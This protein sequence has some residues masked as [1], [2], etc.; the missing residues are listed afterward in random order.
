MRVRPRHTLGPSASSSAS[1]THQTRLVS[2]EYTTMRIFPIMAPTVLS[3]PKVLLLVSS[4]L[5]LVVLRRVQRVRQAWQAP[6]NSQPAYFVFVSPTSIFGRLFPRVPW[7][8]PGVGFI[9][10]DAYQRQPLLRSTVFQPISRPMTRYLR[11][12]QVRCCSNQVTVPRQYST[13]TTRR[14]YSRQGGFYIDTSK[15]RVT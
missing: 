14:C 15:I 6:G 8:L 2:R 4:L 3:D 7:I 11:S 9:W 10:R 12:I 5:C 1:Y 13:A